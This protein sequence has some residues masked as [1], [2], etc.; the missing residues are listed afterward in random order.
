M[1]PD[2]YPTPEFSVG[3]SKHEIDLYLGFAGWGIEVLVD[4]KDL[5][6]HVTRFDT[7][8]SYAKWGVITEHVVI[9]FRTSISMPIHIM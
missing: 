2:V 7:G 9:D 1:A 6:D 5:K 3:Q 4:G 8:G